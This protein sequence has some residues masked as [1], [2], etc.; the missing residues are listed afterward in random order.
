[1]TDSNLVTTQ[2]NVSSKSTFLNMKLVRKSLFGR[3]LWVNSMLIKHGNP[4]NDGWPKCRRGL[5]ATRKYALQTCSK[6]YGTVTL[7]CTW[8]LQKIRSNIIMYIVVN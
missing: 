4:I 8:N 5:H 1:M 6:M 2:A 7:V 3:I